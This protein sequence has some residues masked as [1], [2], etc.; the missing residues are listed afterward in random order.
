MDEMDLVFRDE[1]FSAD[2]DDVID[3]AFRA[4]S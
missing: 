2:L 4:L 3:R 1:G